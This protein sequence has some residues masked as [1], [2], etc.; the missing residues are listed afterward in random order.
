MRVLN[1]SY[2]SHNYS[3]WRQARSSRGVS[4]P[5]GYRTSEKAINPGQIYSLTHAF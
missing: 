4:I 3:L 1:F 5:F 2:N